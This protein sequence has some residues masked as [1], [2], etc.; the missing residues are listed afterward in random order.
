LL[1]WQGDAELALAE[2][3]GARGDIEGATAALA[4]ALDAYERKGNVAAITHARQLIPGGDTD[5]AHRVVGNPSR[6]RKR[7][8]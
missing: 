4:R 1:D 3:L 2:V 8:P 7:G 6:R 5:R